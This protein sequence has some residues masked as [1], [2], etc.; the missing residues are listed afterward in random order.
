MKAIVFLTLQLPGIDP[1]SR[2]SSSLVSYSLPTANYSQS[3]LVKTKHFDNETIKNYQ[4]FTHPAL[5]IGVIGNTTGEKYARQRMKENNVD[6]NLLILFETEDEMLEALAT[7]K[8]FAIARGSI[9]NEYQELTNPT[10]KTIELKS[11][12]EEMA[13]SVDGKN[14]DLLKALNLAIQSITKNNKISYP[15]WLKDHNVFSHK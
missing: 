12:G 5:K 14:H 3:L 11:F 4:S 2:E 7:D 10:F 8:I 13:Y 1:N 15:Q 6:E 9:G